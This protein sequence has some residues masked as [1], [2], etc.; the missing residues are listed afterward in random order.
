MAYD[1]RVTGK[2]LPLC[3]VVGQAYI[4]RDQVA[5]LQ[6]AEQDIPAWIALVAYARPAEMR[7]SEE[8][9]VRAAAALLANP[10]PRADART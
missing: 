1:L 6:A 3:T 9:L 7:H 5:L 2:A 10:L 8:V 4:G